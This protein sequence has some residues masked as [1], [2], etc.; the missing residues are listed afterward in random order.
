MIKG[1]PTDH[2]AASLVQICYPSRET[3]LIS[4][5]KQ[6]YYLPLSHDVVSGIEITPYNK[7]DLPQV[8]FRLTVNVLRP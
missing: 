8:L 4:K 3:K 2:I 1:H 5:S 6:K 7:I